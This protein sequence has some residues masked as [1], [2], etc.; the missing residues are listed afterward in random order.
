M[1]EP[2]YDLGPNK[3]FGHPARVGHAGEPWIA[4]L[5]KPRLK[6]AQGSNPV[7]QRGERPRHA[8]GRKAA[9]HRRPYTECRLLVGLLG[10]GHAGFNGFEE[11]GPRRLPPRDRTNQRR[12]VKR[13]KRS[14]FLRHPC[15]STEL[16]DITLPRAPP[17]PKEERL[18]AAGHGAVQHQP[19]PPRPDRQDSVD[20]GR[21]RHRSASRR[22]SKPR[23]SPVTLTTRSIASRVPAT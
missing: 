11:E 3:L 6:R 4:P 15:R 2:A 1:K 20:V 8:W 7:G 23:M 5:P 19:R 18:R 12:T 14:I 21:S 16:Q 22:R 17:D 13:P 10:E 9:R